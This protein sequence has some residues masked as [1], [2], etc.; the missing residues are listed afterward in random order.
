[1]LLRLLGKVLVRVFFAMDWPFIVSL[2][3]S[4]N[5]KLL[6]VGVSEVGEIKMRARKQWTHSK[7]FPE[8]II[9]FL[10]ALNIPASK[11]PQLLTKHTWCHRCHQKLLFF[12]MYF[13]NFC[14]N[15][16]NW[17]QRDSNPLPLSSQTNAQAFNQPSQM[18]EICCVD[19]SVGG[20]QKFTQHWLSGVCSNRVLPA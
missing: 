6:K 14:I 4:F 19:L 17:K 8:N 9:K 13:K 18:I 7:G 11:G 5:E 10:G 20:R 3:N 15:K 12:F 2:K 16:R 1:M